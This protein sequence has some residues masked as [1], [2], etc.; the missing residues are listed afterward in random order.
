LL[1]LL[2]DGSK[3]LFPADWTDLVGTGASENDSPATVGSISDLL[4]TLVVC[5]GISGRG[6]STSDRSDPRSSEEGPD[7]TQRSIA[8]V[9][10]ERRPPS[11]TTASA[12]GAARK[13]GRRG[14]AGTPDRRLR[15]S[16]G[17]KVDGRRF[18]PKSNQLT[19]ED[20][21]P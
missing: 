16:T 5:A 12:Q 8:A 19:K 2:P 1:V 3:T 14:P 7:S 18:P 9:L 15:T 20:L 21:H 10:D 6:G 11:T 4:R 13:S 17:V